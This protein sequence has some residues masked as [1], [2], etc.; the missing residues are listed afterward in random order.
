MVLAKPPGALASVDWFTELAPIP[1][2]L[3]IRDRIAVV[4]WPTGAQAA[5]FVAATVSVSKLVGEMRSLRLRH[6]VT[7]VE[8]HEPALSALGA[9]VAATRIWT[10]QRRDWMVN[11]LQLVSERD[12][13][14]LEGALLD[15]AHLFGPRPGRPPH[16]QPRTPGRR[17]LLA[18]RASVLGS[19]HGVR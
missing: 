13:D 10:A 11:L 3:Q 14:R 8:G 15:A 7:C 9:S 12:F 4:C 6:R 5:P 18:G 17:A 19:H 1:D 2:E 16:T